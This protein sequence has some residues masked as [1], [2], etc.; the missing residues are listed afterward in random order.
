MSPLALLLAALD[1][2]ILCLKAAVLCMCA[3]GSFILHELVRTTRA[4]SGCI[5]YLAML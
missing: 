2:L 4:L 3:C 1:A 5:S